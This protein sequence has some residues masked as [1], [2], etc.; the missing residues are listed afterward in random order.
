[1][2][3]AVIKSPALPPQFSPFG[4]SPQRFA[5]P[6]QRLVRHAAKQRGD[7]QPGTCDCRARYY[8]VQRSLR[9]KARMRD[10]PVV[11]AAF[12]ESFAWAVKPVLFARSRRL[13]ALRPADD[14]VLHILVG[15]AWRVMS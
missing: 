11:I 7:R 3:E 1:M 12:L 2:A 6:P 15:E 4:A 9:V 5:L 10:V 8:R 13:I 14:H